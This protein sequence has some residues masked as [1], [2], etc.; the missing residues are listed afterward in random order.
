LCGDSDRFVHA[1]RRNAR[2]FLAQD[3]SDFHRNLLGV[4]Y[5]KCLGRRYWYTL[6]QLSI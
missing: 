6:F 2:G 3:V 5:R 4:S 1:D